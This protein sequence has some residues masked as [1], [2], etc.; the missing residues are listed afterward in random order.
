MSNQKDYL[1]GK[2]QK[3]LECGI[4]ID[5]ETTG[6]G[7]NDTVVELAAVRASDGVV[8]VNSLTAP[9]SIMQKAAEKTH[10]ISEYK[11]LSARPFWKVWDELDGKI[12]D[13][14]YFTSFNRG[15]DERLV[16]QSLFLCGFTG[17]PWNVPDKVFCIMGLANRYF[18]EHLEWDSERSQFKRLSLARCLEIAGIEFKGDP[19]RALT[20]AIAARDLLIYIAEGL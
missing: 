18:A 6:L 14:E 4:I 19:H 17:W 12:V 10:G 1:I 15:F 7:E 3:I 5:T 16:R 2:A 11:A 20:D 8:L 9:K 13:G